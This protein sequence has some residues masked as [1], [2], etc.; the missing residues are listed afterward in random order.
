MTPRP[1]LV[2]EPF[3]AGIPEMIDVLVKDIPGADDGFRLLFSA[4]PFP[5]YQKK[6]TWRRGDTSGN[7]Y[8]MEDPAIEGWLCPAMFRYYRTAPKELYVK[9]EAM[10]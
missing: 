6:L 7:Y 10:K 9:A 3:V 4:Q 1:G 8:R 5:G 2:R